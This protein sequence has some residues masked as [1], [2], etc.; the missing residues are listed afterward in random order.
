MDN[1]EMFVELIP[2]PP[3]SE[4]I[5]PS[6]KVHNAGHEGRG[7]DERPQPLQ[8]SPRELLCP[9]HLRPHIF[10][11]SPLDDGRLP[12][13]T[14]DGG[15]EG[16][17]L[18]L[19]LGLGCGGFPFALPPLGALGVH[20]EPVLPPAVLN[21]RQEVVIVIVV[22]RAD[23]IGEGDADVLLEAR[24]QV[25]LVQDKL[26][27]VGDDDLHVDTAVPRVLD[28]PCLERERR[29]FSVA[30]PLGVDDDARVR[31]DVEVAVHHGE[32]RV[33]VGSLAAPVKEPHRPGEPAEQSRDRE[34]QDHHEA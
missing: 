7:N 8:E 29:V 5:R 15:V 14:F 1:E 32:E 4:H 10:R 22:L 21:R 6:R 3:E 20:K 16:T 27:P 30:V 28:A 2:P 19:G 18:A 31:G 24:E 12:A 9:L 11:D 25:L 26:L 34:A 13:H 17:G 33:A 23:S